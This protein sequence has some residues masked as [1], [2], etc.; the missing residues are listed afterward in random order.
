MHFSEPCPGLLATCLV[1]SSP[2]LLEGPILASEFSGVCKS[3]DTQPSCLLLLSQFPPQVR[4]WLGPS[5]LGFPMGNRPHT[6]M[7]SVIKTMG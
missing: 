6:T 7:R 4:P 1:I 5:L 3:S 2:N